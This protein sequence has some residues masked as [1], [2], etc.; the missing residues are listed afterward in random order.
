MKLLRS[1]FFSFLLALPIAFFAFA[2][3]I[4]DLYQAP[5]TGKALLFISVYESLYIRGFPLTSQHNYPLNE[6]CSQPR[7]YYLLEISF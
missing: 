5:R 1:F 2:R 3:V 6:T 7:S 4:S